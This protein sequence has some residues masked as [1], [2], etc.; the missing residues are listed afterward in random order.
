MAKKSIITTRGKLI[1]KGV[2]S[3]PV[4]KTIITPAKRF[5]SVSIPVWLIVLGLVWVLMVVLY[6]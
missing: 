4:A 3:I 5:I 2:K 6:L 1:P